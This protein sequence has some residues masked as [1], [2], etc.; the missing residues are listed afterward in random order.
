MTTT[1]QSLSF[2]LLL[3]QSQSNGRLFSKS[4]K[5]AI[6]TL[7]LKRSTIFFGKRI[8]LSVPLSDL[9]LR[10]VELG[11]EERCK[12]LAALLLDEGVEAAM[13]RGYSVSS[14]PHLIPHIDRILSSTDPDVILPYLFRG[15]KRCLE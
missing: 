13:C 8:F 15:E 11:V 1:G 4:Y 2:R 9:A 14:M 7:V 12:H 10:L 6:L 3:H 5:L